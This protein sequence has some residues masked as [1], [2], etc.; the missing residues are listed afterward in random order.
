MAAT[1]VQRRRGTTAQHSTFTGLLGEL[2]VDTDKD[3]LVVHDGATAGGFPLARESALASYLLLAGGTLT[4]AL[5]S[6]AGTAA[7]PAV[8]IGDPS[9]GL[10]MLGAAGATEAIGFAANGAVLGNWS[11]SGLRVGDATAAVASALLDL[12]STTKGL[13]VPSM[14]TTQRDA[15]GTPRAGLVIYPG[16]A[17]Q[18]DYQGLRGR[19]QRI[20]TPPAP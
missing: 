15:I 7:L 9:N 1:A 19:V 2:T 12:V 16:Q 4:G 14:T 18:Q 3:T 13:G 11:G 17:V 8:A 6:A 10:Y 5:I 20:L